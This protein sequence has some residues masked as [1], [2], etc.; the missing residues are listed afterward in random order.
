M[1][2]ADVDI[3]VEQILRRYPTITVV[4]ASNHPAKAAHTVP[5][6]MQRHGWRI[7]PVNP[8]GGTILGEPAYPVLADVPEQV[9]FV[10]VFRP[11][12]QAADIVRQ[13]AAVGAGAVWLQLGIVSAEARHIA[14]DAGIQ[15]VENRCLYIEQARLAIEAPTVSR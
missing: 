15:Y 4:G 2:S 14:E 9:E 12:A 5:A 3:L 7:V 13:A 1:S 10:D 6:H 11:S 8:R